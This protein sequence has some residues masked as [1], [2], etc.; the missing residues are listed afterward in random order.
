MDISLQE[1]CSTVLTSLIEFDASVVRGVYFKFRKF[2]V[3]LC[4]LQ[5]SRLN[6]IE[7]CVG[8]CLSHFWLL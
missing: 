4:E 2:Y 3:V 6:D 1:L 8:P 7:M 5:V